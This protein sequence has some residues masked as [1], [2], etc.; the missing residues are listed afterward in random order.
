MIDVSP[1]ISLPAA[2][3]G[4][5]TVLL[6]ARAGVE[7]YVYYSEKQKK[8]PQ[9]LGGVQASRQAQL[10]A[11]KKVIQRYYNKYSRGA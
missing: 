1:L 10:S 6:I 8:S 7:A 11:S 4:F 5:I 2:L 9:E 3:I